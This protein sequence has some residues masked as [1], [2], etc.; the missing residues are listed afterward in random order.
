MKNYQE[1]ST[2]GKCTVLIM[3]LSSVSIKAQLNS[4]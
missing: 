1:L 4:D 2:A 3:K